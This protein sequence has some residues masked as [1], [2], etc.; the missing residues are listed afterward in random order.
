MA[1]ETCSGEDFSVYVWGTNDHGALCLPSLEDVVD[2]QRL[3]C[4]RSHFSRCI[5]AAS[6]ISLCATASDAVLQWG[7]AAGGLPCPL[8]G[9]P[10]GC[11][12]LATD[13]RRVF[14]LTDEG[15]VFSWDVVAPPATALSPSRLPIPVDV[16]QL[17]CGNTHAL[18]LVEGGAVYSWG[19]GV[20]GQLGRE[21][22]VGGTGGGSVDGVPR[23]MDALDELHLSIAS[24]ACGAVHS[25]LLSASGE[26]VLCGLVH[27]ATLLDATAAAAPRGASSRSPG[28]TVSLRLPVAVDGPWAQADG[29]AAIACGHTHTLAL[30]RTGQVFSFGEGGA[31]QLGLAAT[32]PAG[33]PM[34]VGGPLASRT[35]DR[36][37]AGACFSVARVAPATGGGGPACFFWG[38]GGGGLE[39]AVRVPSE[40]AELGGL[41]VVDVCGSDSHY[42]ALTSGGDVYA[43]GTGG[44]G[45][46][47]LQRRDPI[48]SPQRLTALDRRRISVVS[49]GG[50]EGS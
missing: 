46:L 23:R 5:S 50:G 28:A 37:W 6:D 32:V 31:P 29:L 9:A 13:G 17:A 44:R 49:C 8:P 48:V 14:A 41:D 7:G 16:E 38:G 30:S 20:E 35:V 3:L 40:L 2:P 36:I 24:V 47:G 21:A 42:L 34:R 18:A 45:A 10:A 4:L 12:S 1:V 26:L 25:A 15:H 19:R 22:S 27:S 33:R 43:W 11:H 39:P